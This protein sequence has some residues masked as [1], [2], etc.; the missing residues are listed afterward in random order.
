MQQ[1]IC[2][3]IDEI[4]ID[5]SI[6]E[7]L[8]QHLING[9]IWYVNFINDIKLNEVFNNYDKELII[10]K[11]FL[12]IWKW[13]IILNENYEISEIAQKFEK[14]GLDL[15]EIKNLDW[16][17]IN[18][19]NYYKYFLEIKISQNGINEIEKLQNLLKEEI[20]KNTLYNRIKILAQNIIWYKWVITTTITWILIIWTL[21]F[22]IK[23]SKIIDN[24]PLL[25]SIIDT[26]LLEEFENISDSDEYYNSL[27]WSISNNEIP[28]PKEKINNVRVKSISDNQKIF[29]I[30][31]D[32]K[33]IY[34]TIKKE[35]WQFYFKT[36]KWN[37][38]P[39]LWN[40]IRNTINSTN[41]VIENRNT[42]SNEQPRLPIK[43]S[44]RY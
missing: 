10:Q 7:T 1:Y 2:N 42:Y 17:W 34:I 36:E 27:S 3:K 22:D 12:N 37:F 43:E 4:K 18:K 6:L 13:N 44:M 21:M 15:N 40:N 39:I 23:F 20:N 41:N 16:E 25:W 14:T 32:Q 24:I 26:E 8:K 28:L 35:N 31:T 9:N 38:R 5:L 29:Q 19:S 11:V 30:Q 33:K